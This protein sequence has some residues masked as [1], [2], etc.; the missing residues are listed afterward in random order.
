MNAASQ[1]VRL[2]GRAESRSCQ[3]KPPGLT[4]DI[5]QAGVSTEPS[6]VAGG[7]PSSGLTEVFQDAGRKALAELHHHSNTG[8]HA[9]RVLLGPVGAEGVGW[10]V[11]WQ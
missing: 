10:A 11:G 2:W 6:S 1:P 4:R 9:E 7:V 3:G 8:D 5:G